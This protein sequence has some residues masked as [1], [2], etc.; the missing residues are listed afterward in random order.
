MSENKSKVT[1][2]STTYCPSCQ[3]LKKWLTEQQITYEAVNVEEQPERQEE[4]VAKSG[5]FFVPVTLIKH[6]DGREEV[7]QGT[8]YSQIKAAL[9]RALVC[10]SP[11]DYARGYYERIS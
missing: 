9:G 5:G 6:G 3:T 11:G 4:L 7:V 1:V 2:F 8:Q 10:L